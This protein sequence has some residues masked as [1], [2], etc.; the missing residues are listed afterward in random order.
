MLY[1]LALAV[2]QPEVLRS[3]VTQSKVTFSMEKEGK[4][5]VNTSPREKEESRKRSL[6]AIITTDDPGPG[7][8]ATPSEA[9]VDLQ[10]PRVPCDDDNVK[11][12]K[13]DDAQAN[14]SEW[15][16]RA[17]S[18]IPGGYSAE[19]HDPILDLY[20]DACLRWYSNK[21]RKIFTTYLKLT[22][23]KDWYKLAHG[24]VPVFAGSKRKR[25]EEAEELLPISLE[26]LD[27][28]APVRP[29]ASASQI[30]D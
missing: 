13:N 30:G 21:V 19:T 6:P 8:T 22:Y 29:P 10:L 2:L 5:E 9:K 18:R 17:G 16:V 15:N 11:A 3:P 7:P 20:R 4:G 27:V 24:K 14:T 28:E 26:D 12:A 25:D 1:R 23:G